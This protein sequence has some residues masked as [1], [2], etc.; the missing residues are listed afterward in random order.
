M[1]DNQED[2]KHRGGCSRVAS[3]MATISQPVAVRP[4]AETRPVT[5]ECFGNPVIEQTEACGR[6][7]GCQFVLIQRVRV[8][9]PVEFGAAVR[10]CEPQ[11]E[12]GFPKVGHEPREEE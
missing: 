1:R 9:V 4:F 11:I 5:I 10:I 7:G 6:P 2:T 8:E 12:C 3:Q